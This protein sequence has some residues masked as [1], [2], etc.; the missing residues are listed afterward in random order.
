MAGKTIE[1]GEPKKIEFSIKNL[2][3]VYNL[4]T[5]LNIM[6]SNTVDLPVSVNDGVAGFVMK[7][8]TY[9]FVYDT[10]RRKVKLSINREDNNELFKYHHHAHRFHIHYNP[11]DVTMN[12]KIMTI[13]PRKVSFKVWDVDKDFT[14]PREHQYTQKFTE[15]AHWNNTH[16]DQTVKGNITSEYFKYPNIEPS[17]TCIAIKPYIGTGIITDPDFLKQEW[18]GDIF[19]ATDMNQKAKDNIADLNHFDWD[20][21]EYAWR[22]HDLVKV[23]DDTYNEIGQLYGIEDGYFC[24][25]LTQAYFYTADLN[26]KRLVVV[27]SKSKEGWNLPER[28]MLI[29]EAK[30][31]KRPEKEE[32]PIKETVQESDEDMILTVPFTGVVYDNSDMNLRYHNSR[33][34][35]DVSYNYYYHGKKFENED[36]VLCVNSIWIK[37]NPSKLMHQYLYEPG[38]PSISPE[39][40]GVMTECDG[41]VGTFNIKFFDK[42]IKD[43]YEKLLKEGKFEISACCDSSETL[44]GTKTD[45]DWRT[46]RYCTYLIVG[47]NIECQKTPEMLL[48]F[49]WTGKVF[50]EEDRCGEADENHTKIIF[51]EKKHY[52]DIY[53]LMMD[54]PGKKLNIDPL[55]TN[56]RKIPV[57][58]SDGTIIGHVYGINRSSAEITVRFINHIDYI[59]YQRS[60]TESGAMLSMVAPDRHYISGIDDSTKAPIKEYNI[61]YM[62]VDYFPAIQKED[63]FD[64]PNKED[65]RERIESITKKKEERHDDLPAL[66]ASLNALGFFKSVNFELRD[67]HPVVCYAGDATVPAQN[68]EFDLLV[69]ESQKILDTPPEKGYKVDYTS[70]RSNYLSWDRY[71]MGIALLSSFR[72]K[73]PSTQVGACIVKDRKIMSVG[74]NGF[75][76]G[77]RDDR[78][79]WSKVNQNPEDNKYAYVVHAELNAILN[80]PGITLKG[81]TLYTTLFPCNECAKAII[82]AGIKKV[83]YHDDGNNKGNLLKAATERMFKAA[84]V[85]TQAFTEGMIEID[86]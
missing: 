80:F 76:K 23:T 71:F 56:D 52:F 24:I 40:I 12:G 64:I 39:P 47:G 54:S 36:D 67:G 11:E 18:I 43:E 78:F 73:D 44:Y 74:Y 69:D 42:D 25:N 27:Y 62:I 82:Q 57:F 51:D 29:D 41:E 61:S 9:R 20:F 8:G 10:F 5:H 77:C 55:L 6:V 33:K 28:L 81:S 59:F 16:P 1:R 31:P 85:K 22:T 84:G 19:Y 38:S 4:N 68:I 32:E 35:F 66:L 34:I 7:K 2:S 70:K 46:V 63:T 58:A 86:Y 14:I 65:V 53:P 79:P 49:H 60:I 21:P 50:Y 37:N 45:P 30:L 75:P 83:V 26:F 72:S 17:T 15:S 3:E 13:V 48:T